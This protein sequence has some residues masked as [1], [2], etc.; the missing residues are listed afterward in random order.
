MQYLVPLD[1][2]LTSFQDRHGE[3]LDQFTVYRLFSGSDQ[4][5]A[6][7]VAEGE[8]CMDVPVTSADKPRPEGLQISSSIDPFFDPFPNPFRVSVLS[9]FKYHK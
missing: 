7:G 3:E 4:L 1:T 6:H 2:T 9:R 8:A 5:A